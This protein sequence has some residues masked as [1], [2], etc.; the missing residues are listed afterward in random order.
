MTTILIPENLVISAEP[1][2]SCKSFVIPAKAL[3]FL[4]KVVTPAKAG[5]GIQTQ[6]QCKSALIRV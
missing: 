6:K 1:C 3:S 4:R 2:H 5:A